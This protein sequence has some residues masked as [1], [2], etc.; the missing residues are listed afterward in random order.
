M[1]TLSARTGEGFADWLA[2]L[3]RGVARARCA[4]REHRRGAASARR[5]ARIRTRAFDNGAITLQAPD[6]RRIRNGHHRRTRRDE[7]HANRGARRRAGCGIPAVRLPACA[8]ARA[9]GLGQQRRRG[10]HDRSRGRSLAH[11]L[12][13]AAP[14]PGRASARAHRP[15]RR[16]AIVRHAPSP[17][18]RSSRACAVMPPRRSGPTARSATI[19]SPSSSIP[20]IAAIATRSSTAPTAARA[21]RSRARCRTTAR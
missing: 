13:D 8:R 4:P 19:A 9:R 16:S 12:H 6:G 14:H 1:I 10:R 11:R 18:S 3:E 21:T 15:Y 5:R 2:W 7:A 20:A 17:A